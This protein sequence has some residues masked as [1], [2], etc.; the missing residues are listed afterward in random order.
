MGLLEFLHP[1]SSP[2]ARATARLCEIAGRVE[3]L[4]HRLRAHA[5]RCTM[6]TM[7]T[8]VVE[9]ADAQATQLKIMKTILSDLNAW[10]RPPE[11][12]AHQGLNNWERLSGDLIELSAI[13]A[14]TA[15]SVLAWEN[16][17]AETAE[18][19]NEIAGEESASVEKL[20]KLA[21][22]CDPQALD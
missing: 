4:E 10:P 12:P 13:T 21:L 5:A 8:G 20:R 18:T 6:A 1:S 11:A 19:L 9:I 22:K 14:D 3:A 16:V 7:R 17:D 2:E 15:R